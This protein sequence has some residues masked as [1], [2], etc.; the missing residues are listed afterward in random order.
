MMFLKKNL[1]KCLDDGKAQKVGRQLYECLNKKRC[2][3]KFFDI[4]TCMCDQAYKFE[5]KKEKTEAK[6]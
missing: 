2:T 6:K 4:A 1:E 5:K 3:S